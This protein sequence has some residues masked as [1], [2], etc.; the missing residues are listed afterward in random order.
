[1]S[2][3]ELFEDYSQRHEK[4]TLAGDVKKW[5]WFKIYL[6]SKNK[7]DFV[8]ELKIFNSLLMQHGLFGCEELSA[9]VD[10]IYGLKNLLFFYQ[11]RK[12]KMKM[13]FN[14][15]VNVWRS[16]DENGS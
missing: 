3:F 9:C 11:D 7:I 4:I 6:F 16:V 14:S 2:V 12:K 1:M 5:T 8:K 15:L 10:N 13:A